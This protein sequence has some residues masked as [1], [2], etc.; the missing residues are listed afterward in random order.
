M[1]LLP[2]FHYRP[3]LGWINDPIGFIQDDEGRFHLFVQHVPDG[4]DWKPDIQWSH[5]ISN[6][7]VHWEFVEPALVPEGHG[8]DGFGCWSGSAVIDGNVPTLI[9]S[10]L[11]DPADGHAQQVS[12][13]RGSAE[14]HTWSREP[15]NPVIAGP[16]PEL[17]AIGFRDPYVWREDD[18][19]RM[20]MGASVGDEAAAILGYSSHDLLDWT[21]EG[22]VYQRSVNERDDLWTGRLWECPQLPVLGNERLLLAS[23]WHD[24]H[25]LYVAALRG[26]MS[27]MRFEPGAPARFDHGPDFYSAAAMTDTD[28]RLVVVGW[29]REDGST[30]T[31]AEGWTGMISVPRH[32]DVDDQG[33][34]IRPIS[35]LEQLRGDTVASGLRR[36]AAGTVEVIA[37]A[38]PVGEVIVRSP[39]G[40]GVRLDVF[41]DSDGAHSVAIEYSP[42]RREIIVDRATASPDASSQETRFAAPLTG[43]FEELKLRVYL[44]KTIVEVFAND[45]VAF[46]VRAYPSEGAAA[47]TLTADSNTQVSVAAWTLSQTM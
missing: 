25:F 42:E 17:H 4:V 38:L 26:Q 5:G 47:V 19:W 6:D 46:T 22:I 37:E 11:G 30:T 14:W 16:P 18:S 27:G 21:Y 41:A 33:L 34:L 10:A 45:R 29:S 12:V 44:D 28:G 9:Y 32:V 35:E 31:Q 2:A 13:A 40:V 20:I 39:I 3:A 43:D 1:S 7:L 8:S 15:V 24:D 36:L 23:V